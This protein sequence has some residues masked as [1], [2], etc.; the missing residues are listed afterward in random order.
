MNRRSAVLISLAALAAAAAIVVGVYGPSG[1]VGGGGTAD[2]AEPPRFV[3]EGEQL[4]FEPA[5]EQP[6]RGETDLEPGTEL[7]VRLRSTGENPFLKSRSAT[8]DDSGAFEA[9]FDLSDV[10]EGT[11][12]EVVITRDGARYMNT[13]GEVTA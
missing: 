4:A 10:D 8:V 1:L 7:A 3:Y 2:A 12:F 13:T 11:T 9:T 6:V 5:P